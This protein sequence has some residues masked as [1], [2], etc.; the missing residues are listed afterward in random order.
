M[1]NLPDNLTILTTYDT[2]D[3][4]AELLSQVAAEDTSDPAKIILVNLDGDAA[5]PHI[6]KECPFPHTVFSVKYAHIGLGFDSYAGIR[7]MR[8]SSLMGQLDGLLDLLSEEVLILAGPDPKA[9]IVLKALQNSEM[10]GRIHLWAVK[11]MSV[12]G[13]R[14]CEAYDDLLSDLQGVK[15][16]AL[17]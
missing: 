3:V 1:I 4:R 10:R 13:K 15:S 11:P 16:F 5:L 12:M 9:L 14:R 17:S 2:I 8:Y 6:E 7:S